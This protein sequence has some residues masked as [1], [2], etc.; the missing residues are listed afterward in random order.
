MLKSLAGFKTAAEAAPQ[1]K[2]TVPSRGGGVDMFS[3]RM[4]MT[5]HEFFLSRIIGVGKPPPQTTNCHIKLDATVIRFQP[6]EKLHTRIS[7]LAKVRDRSQELQKQQLPVRWGWNFSTWET[8]KK[9]FGDVFLPG[10]SCCNKPTSCSRV[11]TLNTA[12]K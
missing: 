5:P 7:F 9:T 8:L 6:P 3:M 2:A 1:P 4:R 12:S 10:T 11:A